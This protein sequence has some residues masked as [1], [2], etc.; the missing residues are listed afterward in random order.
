MSDSVRHGCIASCSLRRIGLYLQAACRRHHWIFRPKTPVGEG[1]HRWH[2]ERHLSPRLIASLTAEQR[3]VL[4]LG[5]AFEIDPVYSREGEQRDAARNTVMWGTL[6][7]LPKTS[8][9]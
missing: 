4:M 8:K 9:L 3:S 7:E 1:N 2:W 5:E 6:D